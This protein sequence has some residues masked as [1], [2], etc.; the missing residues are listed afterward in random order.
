MNDNQWTRRNFMKS[1]GAMTALAGVSNILCSGSIKKPNIIIIY[2]DDQDFSQIGCYGHNVL[3]PNIDSLAS[4]GIKFSRYYATS[5]VCTPSRYSVLTGRYAGRSPHIQS[6]YETNSPSFLRWN[7]FVSKGELTITHLLKKSGYTTGMVGKWHLG[8]DLPEKE[9]EYA[10]PEDSV[11]SKKLKKNYKSMQSYVKQYGGFDYVESVYGNNLH[12]INIPQTL[13]YHNQDWVTEGAVNFIE[14][15]QSTPFFLYMATTIPHGP[16]PLESMKA[17]PRITPS[18]I[19]EKAPDVQPS[20]EDVFSRI[21][22]AGLPEN[23]APLTWLDDGIGAVLNKLKEHHL[24]NNT[25]VILASDHGTKRGK[26][27]CY[28]SAA[29]TPCLMRWPSKIKPGTTCDDIVANID[30]V[31]TI[32]DVCNI[33]PATYYKMDGLSLKELL[34]HSKSI[35]RESLYLEVVFQRA[36][37]TKEWKYIATRFPLEVQKKITKENRKQF[38]IEGK[39]GKDRYGNDKNFPA[40]YDDDQLYNIKN[41]KRELNNLAYIKKYSVKLENMQKMMSEYVQDLPHTFGEF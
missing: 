15:N 32:L 31:P 30:F 39:M 1:M 41:D 2:T 9:L 14:Q 36:V 19:L 13:Q 11:I 26:M 25:L 21:K 35:D 12:A 3:T 18:G 6:L 29:N 27:S 23:T 5:P 8:Q 10:D 34:L 38:T 40:Y 28:E 22:A 17:D 16:S 37:V 24:E 33:N 20:R 4:D 7:S